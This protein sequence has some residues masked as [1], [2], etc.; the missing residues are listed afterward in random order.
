MAT[1][2]TRAATTS[3]R[4]T[5]ASTKTTPTT[6]AAAPGKATAKPAPAGP[7]EIALP[8]VPI[9]GGKPQLAKVMKLW[10]TNFV[11][12]HLRNT[13]LRHGP[14][15]THTNYVGNTEAFLEK[16]TG[17][18]TMTVGDG[19]Q[20][21]DLSEA[22]ARHWLA[23]IWSDLSHHN[24]AGWFRAFGYELLP[25]AIEPAPDPPPVPLVEVSYQGRA[26]L[27][28]AVYGDPTRIVVDDD[29][30][31]PTLQDLARSEQA[32]VIAASR[33]GV[34]GCNRCRHERDRQAKK[35]ARAAAKGAPATR[36]PAAKK[37]P[38]A[39][40]PAAKKTT[41]GRR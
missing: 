5:T 21:Y 31:P 11:S 23:S 28:G 8:I 22:A 6:K 30:G 3:T 36:R 41:P 18:T 27:V 24:L 9:P 34:C 1:V 39:R 37:A 17:R 15:R 16:P 25:G 4:K 19:S 40:R 13:L 26:Y 14:A 35:V 20:T 32:K 7:H 33:T 12:P 38:A 2:R 29:F 10:F